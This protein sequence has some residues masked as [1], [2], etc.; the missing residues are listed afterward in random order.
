VTH[1]VSQE[2]AAQI[3]VIDY[4]GSQYRA[5]FWVGQGRAYEDSVERLA[6]QR[7]LPAHGVRIA[8]IGA[9]FGRL[10]D[11]YLGYDQIILFDYS[12]TLLQEAARDRGHDPRFV[13]VA[14]NLYSLPLASASL[15]TL[16][17]VRVM[18]HLADVPTALAQ[19]RRVLHRYSV[20]VI[21]YAN[22]RNLKALMR[23]GARRQD[24][25]PLDQEPVEFVKLNFDF[26]PDWMGAQ[27]RNAGLRI[28]Q[29]YAVSHFRLPVLKTRVPA[30][31]LAQVDSWLFAA[32]G[33]YPLSPS[34]FL[35]A[36][37]PQG[38]V[39]KAISLDPGQVGQLF[40]CPRCGT[41]GLDQVTEEVV[42]C[43]HCGANY[44]KQHGV[45]DLKEPI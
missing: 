30:A 4:E 44:A 29:R 45:W 26:H 2:V 21:E 32:G 36:D 18:H 3:P 27:F 25:S 16:V 42:A 23:W 5:D 40:R 31:K 39:R 15:D 20:A 37:A 28:R 22:K 6:L 13:F 12:R 9:G 24:W 14:G 1:S 11:L 8:E 10:S 17:M 41:E 43:K 33:N 34:V 19:L 38:T 35:Q 7:L